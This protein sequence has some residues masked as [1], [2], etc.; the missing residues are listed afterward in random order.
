MLRE[1]HIKNIAVIED[2]TISFGDGFH[3]LTGET[4]AGKSDRLYQYGAR[5]KNCKGFDSHRC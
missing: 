1:L 3:A 5:R 4:G 2:I